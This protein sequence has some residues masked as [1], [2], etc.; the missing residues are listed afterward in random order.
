MTKDNTKSV[1]VR[2]EHCSVICPRT[3]PPSCLGGNP[4]S[5]SLGNPLSRFPGRSLSNPLT[6]FLSY[7]PGNPLSNLGGNSLSDSL[8]YPLSHPGG[9]PLGGTPTLGH[10]WYNGFIKQ[11]LRRI[12]T[13]FLTLVITNLFNLV[14]GGKDAKNKHRFNYPNS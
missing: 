7:S 13:P 14:K 11:W 5:H 10:F 12:F 9:H 4:L 6:C 8:G 2:I 3:N 1:V